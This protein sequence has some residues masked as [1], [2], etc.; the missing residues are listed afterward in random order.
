MQLSTGDRI[1]GSEHLIQRGTPSNLKKPA[2]FADVLES[3][4]EEV[5]PIATRRQR[6]IG[7]V[8]EA[9]AD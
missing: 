5:Q 8:G 9:G 1:Q 7:R 6:K 2:L 4:V 3:L